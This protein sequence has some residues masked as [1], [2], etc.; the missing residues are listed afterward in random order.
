MPATAP[1]GA[2]LASVLEGKTKKKNFRKSKAELQ[3]QLLK[4]AQGTNG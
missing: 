3:D 1:A 2:M 4:V